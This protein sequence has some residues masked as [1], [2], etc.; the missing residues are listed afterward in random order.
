MNQRKK[1]PEKQTYRAI[2]QFVTVWFIFMLESKCWGKFK[3]CV[4]A[5]QAAFSDSVVQLKTANI[6]FVIATY[7]QLGIRSFLN[8]VSAL[9]SVLNEK[10]MQGIPQSEALS[11]STAVCGLVPI[12]W[13]DYLILAFLVSDH[14]LDKCPAEKKTA[15]LLYSDRYNI[16]TSC[17]F[18]YMAVL[19]YCLFSLN[20]GV[21]E[22]PPKKNMQ[23]F[24]FFFI[25]VFPHKV[26]VFSFHAP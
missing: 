8:S 1:V 3:L 2:H 12:V 17:C 10:C 20:S 5:Q 16:T 6:Q 24:I 14:G 13:C 23:L 7:S 21:A 15:S 19:Y 25:T 4:Q 11:F 26:R 9:Q 22:N 18:K